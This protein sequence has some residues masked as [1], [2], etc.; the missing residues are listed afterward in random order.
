MREI[1]RMTMHDFAYNAMPGRIVFRAGAHADIGDELARL[2]VEHAMITTSPGNRAT[3]EWVAAHLGDR[4][5]GLYDDA[6]AHVPIEQAEAACRWAREKGADSV[7]S[8]GGG[9]PIGLAKAVAHEIGIPIIAVPTTYSGSEMTGLVGVTRDGVKRTV[10]GPAILPKT[11]IYDS[12]LTLALPP[13]ATAATGM[14][15]IAHCI[16]ALYVPAANPVSSTLAEAGL[17]AL[18]Q[19]LPGAV[20]K[21]DDAEARDRALYGAYLAGAA[22]GATGIAIHHKVCHALGGSFGVSHGDANAIILPQ[23]VAF[24]AQA[25]AGPIAAAARAMGASDDLS[26]EAA[27][28][29]APFLFDFVAGIGAPNS[30]RAVG[31]AESALDDAA[32]IAM[33]LINDNPRPVDY[34]SVRALLD[35]AWHGRRPGG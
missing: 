18:V 8:I 7:V 28:A 22:L 16:E 5:V 14:N 11:V 24:N 13:G 1:G 20:A 6:A 33:E 30:L 9:S 21:G 34:Q 35:D 10:A 19:G 23:A 17:S 12:A 26:D 4:C 29:A 3:A 2:K 27:G 32:R 25:A 15:A 31:F